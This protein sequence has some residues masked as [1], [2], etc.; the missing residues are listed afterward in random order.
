MGVGEH[1]SPLLGCE[2]CGLA[3]SPP[4]KARLIN[5]VS[6]LDKLVKQLLDAVENL[7]N[8]FI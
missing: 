5:M 4:R 8:E 3:A 2:K 1:V 6:Y 7:V